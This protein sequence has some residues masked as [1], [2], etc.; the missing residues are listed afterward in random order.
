MDRKDLTW[1]KSSWSN[2]NASECVE[3]AQ[4]DDDRRT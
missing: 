3:V 2:A 4:L 1:R